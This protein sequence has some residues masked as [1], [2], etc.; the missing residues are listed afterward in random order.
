MLHFKN[1]V[2]LNN[3]S[4][5][6]L[7]SK[8]LIIE[9]S[10]KENLLKVF[11]KSS[12][13]IALF[14]VS[15]LTSLNLHASDNEFRLGIDNFIENPPFE[16]IDREIILVAN[17]ASRT[18]NNLSTVDAII[19]SNKFKLK[20]I[21]VPE[22]GYF[23]SVP[24]GETVA[25]DNLNGIPL[26]SLYGKSKTPSRE[27]IQKCDA[28]VIDIQDIGVRSYTYLSTVYNVLAVA[29]DLGKKVYILDRPNPLGG[30]IVDGT[31]LDINYKSFVGIIPVT[32]LHGCTMGE[33][34]YMMNSEKW[35]KTKD[36]KSVEC[37]LEILKMSNWNRWQTWEDLG[38]HWIPTSPHIPTV[39]AIRG[40][41]TLG[42]LGE[43]GVMSIGIGTTLPF[44]YLG[45]TDFDYE[46]FANFI[47]FEN[48]FND[49][50]VELTK[51]KYRPFYGMGSG[52]NLNGVLFNYERTNSMLPYSFGIEVLNYLKTHHKGIFPTDNSK[53]DMFNKTNGTNL[54]QRFINNEVTLKEIKNKINTDRKTFLD[55]RKKYL[56]YD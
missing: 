47:D 53:Y 54:Y 7:S 20:Y 42:T 10:F 18:S 3:I 28:I 49:Y 30:I 25:D 11:T 15:I 44:Q 8:K 34:T 45:A 52:K 55:F 29:A 2:K 12:F 16:L 50:G 14:C 33:L 22:H 31:L 5:I 32:Y 21:L 35:L 48:S 1:L 26:I 40:A 6:K 56:L 43:L 51:V 39:N 38:L 19:K 23:T 46:K 17:Q 27:L 24:A 37:D 41:A 9:K 13:L 36:G 4:N